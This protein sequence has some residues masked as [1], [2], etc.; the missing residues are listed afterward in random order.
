VNRRCGLLPGRAGPA[1]A[2]VIVA[3]AQASDF[4]GAAGDP[5]STVL[6][7]ALYRGWGRRVLILG[8]HYCLAGLAPLISR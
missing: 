5:G 3:L 8:L 4:A 2:T 6:L 7:E 1:A